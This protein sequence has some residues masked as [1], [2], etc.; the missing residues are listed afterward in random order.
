M[1]LSIQHALQCIIYISAPRPM[2]IA[3]K[4]SDYPD[5]HT[6]VAQSLQYALEPLFQVFIQMKSIHYIMFNVSH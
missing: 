4:D 2:Y 5:G 3:S 1:F 6:V